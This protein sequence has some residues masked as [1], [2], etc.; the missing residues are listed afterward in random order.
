MGV[1]FIA[2]NSLVA[3]IAKRVKGIR[4]MG[5]YIDDSSGCGLKED[6]ALYEPYQKRYPRDQVTLLRLWDELG[7]PHKEKKQ[8]HGSPLPVIGINVDANELSFT[9]TKEA[10]ERL[11]KELEWWGKPG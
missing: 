5:N 11:E 7:V 1:L 3:W 8:I 9:L 10:K 4:Y 6:F 2:F